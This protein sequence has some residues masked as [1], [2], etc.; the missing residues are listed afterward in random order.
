MAGKEALNSC[1]RVLSRVTL[2]AERE[3]RPSQRSDDGVTFRLVHETVTGIGI[4]L[5]IVI[6]PGSREETRP[7]LGAAGKDPVFAAVGGDYR[8]TTSHVLGDEPVV[9]GS[10]VDLSARPEQ[11]RV[12]TAE[13][14]PYATDETGAVGA[15]PQP[16]DD[17]LD[18]VDRVPPTAAEVAEKPSNATP[19]ATSDQIGSYRQISHR[20]DAIGDAPNIVIKPEPLMED[21]DAGP[22]TSAFRSGQV[23]G[24]GIAG[25]I[26]SQ[27]TSHVARP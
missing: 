23:A 20:G 11:E 21:H 16:G 22:G 25:D 10:D 12:A 8:T 3:Q 18:L 7:L 13:T 2:I 5:H 17:R 27:I 14:E 4:E 1:P 26:Q 24:D 19:A 15:R 9:G 6:N